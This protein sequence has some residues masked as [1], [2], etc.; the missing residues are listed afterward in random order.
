MILIY[1]FFTEIRADFKI[2]G[3]VSCW[4]T[5]R[6]QSIGQNQERS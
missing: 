1:L 4:Q 6:N 5:I 2:E 3:T